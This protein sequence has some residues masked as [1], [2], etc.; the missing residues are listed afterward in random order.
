MLS[1]QDGFGTAAECHP[2]PEGINSYSTRFYVLAGF[3]LFDILVLLLHP[4]HLP[5]R[6]DLR[7]GEEALP[8]N[9]LRVSTGRNGVHGVDGVRHLLMAGAHPKLTL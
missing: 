9:L 5:L 3:I 6:Q 2:T 4:R 8:C 1:R 7:L